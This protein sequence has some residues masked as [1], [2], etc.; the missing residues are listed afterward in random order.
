MGAI[1]SQLY[2]IM[3]LLEQEYIDIIN[4]RLDTHASAS[5][6]EINVRSPQTQNN[7]V[8]SIEKH[9]QLSLFG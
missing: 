8:I 7:K 4:Q 3:L 6:L 1:A 9:K 5:D 2:Q